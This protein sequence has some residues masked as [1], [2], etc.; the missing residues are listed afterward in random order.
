MELVRYPKLCFVIIRLF[1]PMQ[2]ALLFVYWSNVF[3]IEETVPMLLKPMN[4]NQ[5]T[6]TIVNSDLSTAN[7]IS[8]VFRNACPSASY[9]KLPNATHVCCQFWNGI[10]TY[11][12][13]QIVSCLLNLTPLSLSVQPLHNNYRCYS[14]FNPSLQSMKVEVLCRE[15]RFF[16]FS[17]DTLH[18][19][20]VCR[21]VFPFSPI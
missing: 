21:H 5:F 9:A 14:Y 11:A 20:A 4:G 12:S 13:I 8:S 7:P 3:Y 16:I 15:F 19:M 6:C 10:L 2:K 17:Q 1:F 18:S